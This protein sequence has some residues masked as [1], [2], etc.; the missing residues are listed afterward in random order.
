[1]F[2]FEKARASVVVLTVQPS[3]YVEILP[4]KVQYP[5]IC[6]LLFFPLA[7]V[8]T[9]F[10]QAR[11]TSVF[12]LPNNHTTNPTLFVVLVKSENLL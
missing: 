1:M 4:K 10:I 3:R 12:S 2:K 6:P 11:S 7:F 8:S 5:L 9:Y